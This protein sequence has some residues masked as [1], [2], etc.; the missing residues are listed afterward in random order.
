MA[1]WDLAFLYLLGRRHADLLDVVLTVE[2]LAIDARTAGFVDRAVLIGIRIA[3]EAR[4]FFC[5]A[6]RAEVESAAHGVGTVELDVVRIV[7]LALHHSIAVRI[8]QLPR[9]VQR[10]LGGGPDMP[11]KSVIA[12]ALP[13]SIELDQ[14]ADLAV[15][16]GHVLPQ[17][18]VIQ[19]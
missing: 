18:P 7:L 17:Q 6:E 1:L 19:P 16:P 14:R 2:Q 12:G 10:A 11:Q 3:E 9:V 5:R 15:V 8:P 13:F 4:D